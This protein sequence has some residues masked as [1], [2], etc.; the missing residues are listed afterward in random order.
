[1]ATDRKVRRTLRHS[2]NGMVLVIVLWI[3]TLLAV[4]AGGFAYSMR[5]ETRLATSTV[6]R[7]QARL[8]PK[9]AWPMLAWQLDRR[10]KTVAAKR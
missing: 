9:P 2:Q 10:R 4:M 3:M 7:A 1:M 6:E 5:I 8:W